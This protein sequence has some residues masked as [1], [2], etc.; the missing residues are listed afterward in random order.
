MGISDGGDGSCSA[1]EEGPRGAEEGADGGGEQS[2]GDVPLTDEEFAQRLY[3]EEHHAHMLELA[4][5][6]AY[7]L[8]PRPTLTP[9]TCIHVHVP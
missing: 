5:Y 2:D 8:N 4:G 7:T 1:G 6:G 3:E 9:Q